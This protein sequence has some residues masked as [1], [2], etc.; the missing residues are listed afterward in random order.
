MAKKKPRWLRALLFP[1]RVAALLALVAL[2]VVAGS[3]A[4]LRFM[5]T[6]EELAAVI[7]SQLQ[8][9]LQRP[10]QM[11]DVNVMLLQGIRIRG[12]RVLEA[13]GFPGPDF[14]TS[15]IAVAKYRWKALLQRRLEF[16]EVRLVSP[17]IQLVRR[18]DGAWNIEGLLRA[19][20][21]E[22]KKTLVLPVGLAADVVSIENAQL[23]VRDL[24]RQRLVAVRNF[25]LEV[26]DF[27]SSDAFPFKL[28]FETTASLGGKPIELKAAGA[29]RISLAGFAWKDA[30]FEFERLR[31]SADGDSL[32]ASG[33]VTGFG[34]PVA[35]VRLKLPRITSET[36]G[37]Y[38]PAP[39][40]IALPPMLAR[41]RFALPKPE[42][43]RLDSVDLAA[44]PLRLRASGQV[45]LGAGGGAYR[46]NVSAPSSSLERVAALWTALSARK[47]AG[48]GD[49]SFTVVGKLG[50]DDRPVI[51]RLG[52]HLKGFG[53]ILSTS[54]AVSGADVTINGSKNLD[55][56]ELH[57]PRGRLIAY[58]NAFSDI[59]LGLRLAE[60]DLDVE[61]LDFTWSVSH[62]KLKGR[63]RNFN[64]PK[65]VDV[66]GS[67]DKLVLQEAIAA[68]AAIV[69]QI[70]AAKGQAVVP[71]SERKWSQVFKYAIP[72]SFPATNG[73]VRI[74]ELVQPNFNTFNV[75]LKWGLRG[76][77][78][79][80]DNVSGWVR[81]GFGP[82][83]VSNIPELENA[84]K[85]LKIIFLPFV[86]MQK[87]NN[88]A[89]F[90]VE[91]LYP[92]TLDFNR[93]YGQYALMAGV[94]DITPFH[95]DS[96]QLVACAQGKVDFPREQV[97]L[98]VFTRLTSPSV[99]LPQYLTDEKGRAS[100]QFFVKDDLN[101]PNAELDVH[102][103]SATAI[104]D[105]IQEGTTRGQALSPQ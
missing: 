6:R 79:G 62:V 28:A 15:E 103:M 53:A 63:I 20:A 54:A 50:L 31:V 18:Q 91:T 26:S 89:R 23:S 95:V 35:D 68:T 59:N 42:L 1:L 75:D 46:L 8:D 11:A 25:D 51:E 96:G 45:S 66:E 67:V 10:V 47:V 65:G 3:A 58:G 32:S 38:W 80:L 74:A 90:S 49:C 83:R 86:F 94:V 40:G 72:K 37:R 43:L 52:L 60:G 13:P 69:Q 48:T 17:R 73:S 78:T 99:S 84:H 81:T 44:E 61:R 36:L 7:S 98:K 29:G 5:L 30:W 71:E 102:K 92:K 34:A 9:A 101:K 22:P 56:L 82:G 70:K 39:S 4:F 24:A 27:S 19:R 76:I 57:A 12:L 41:L 85:L 87:M 14:L 64:A 21:E 88:A 33:R 2:L 77:S 100:I 55:E 93:I 105:C 104:E 16:S 97:A